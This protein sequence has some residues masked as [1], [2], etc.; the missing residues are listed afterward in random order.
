[1]GCSTSKYTVDSRKLD[2]SIHVALR[3]DKKY[4]GDDVTC[5]VP[6]A[7]HPLWIQQKVYTQN[8]IDDSTI[9]SSTCESEEE[10]TCNTN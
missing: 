9:N 1:M 7:A 4:K 5:F 8:A 3:R 6:R 10:A 2:D